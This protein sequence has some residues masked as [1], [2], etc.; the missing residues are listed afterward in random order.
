MDFELDKDQRAWRDE[1]RAFLRQNV[2]P[3]LLDA[4]AERGFEQ[5]GGPVAA[6]RQKVADKGWWG[7]NWPKEYGGIGLGPVYQHILVHEFG[8]WGVPGP[9]LTVT[10]VGPIAPGLG[11]AALN[12]GF[13][14]IR[15]R[16]MSGRMD[17]S[18]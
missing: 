11:V 10:S 13:S 5:P 3:D 4:V 2:T 15:I 7:L 9:D 6:F 16:F 17:G 14:T 12:S 18:R 8:V 1:V